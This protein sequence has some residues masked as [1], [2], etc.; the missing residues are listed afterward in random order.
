LTKKKK[1]QISASASIS[2]SDSWRICN[3][4]KV[5]IQDPRCLT[6]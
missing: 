4:K 6:F 3:I 1:I 5:G 2:E